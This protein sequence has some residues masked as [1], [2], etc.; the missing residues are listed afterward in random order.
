MTKLRKTVRFIKKIDNFVYQFFD[1]VNNDKLYLFDLDDVKL[2]YHRV[3]ELYKNHPDYFD[4]A[5]FA[6][7]YSFSYYQN[8]N[9]LD[10]QKD[11]DKMS[12]EIENFLHVLENDLVH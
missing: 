7:N 3:K 1:E 11:A 12:K 9:L 2:Q 8:N 5:D 6:R 10:Y 4:I